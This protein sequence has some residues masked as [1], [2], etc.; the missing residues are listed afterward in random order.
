MG[1]E[2]AILFDHPTGNTRLSFEIE[3]VI[4]V[5]PVFRSPVWPTHEVTF[6]FS[7]AASTATGPDPMPAQRSIP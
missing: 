6:R 4:A 1:F 3:E 2:P 7:E 5:G